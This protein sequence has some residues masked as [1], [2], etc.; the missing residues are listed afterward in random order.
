MNIFALILY[1]CL[2]NGTACT[3]HVEVDR[4]GMIECAIAGQQLAAKYVSEHPKRVIKGLRCT[5]RPQLFIHTNEASL[6]STIVD[7]GAA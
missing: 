4:L 3:K 5:D 2:A 6:P 7:G 1:T